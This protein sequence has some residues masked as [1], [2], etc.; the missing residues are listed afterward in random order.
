MSMSGSM[1]SPEQ[2]LDQHFREQVSAL[3]SGRF[4]MGVD[5]DRPVR[6]GTKLTGRQATA[7]FEAMLASRHLD[8]AARYLRRE[9]P[10]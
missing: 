1:V 4:E 10:G 8:L 2:Q 3:P 7:L 9:G 6:A 5:L